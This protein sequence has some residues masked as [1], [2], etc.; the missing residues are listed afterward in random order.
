MSQSWPR[1]P[2]AGSGL[3]DAELAELRRAAQLHDIGKIAVP[4]QILHKPGPLDEQEWVFVRQHSV[5]G[6]R[7]LAA[8]PAL[9]S[10]GPIIRSTHERWDGADTQT[11]S[12]A[13]RFPSRRGSSRPATRSR[14]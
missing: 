14:Q 12:S 1:P 2:V 11:G 9:R 13:R 6:E 8:S 7:I 4:D 10:I 3:A 5:V